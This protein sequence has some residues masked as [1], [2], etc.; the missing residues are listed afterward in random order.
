[1]SDNHD[2]ASEEQEGIEIIPPKYHITYTDIFLLEETGEVLLFHNENYSVSISVC[3]MASIMNPANNVP[4]KLQGQ[5][6]SKRTSRSRMVEFCTSEYPTLVEE[7]FQPGC[8]RCEDNSFII[9]KG[10]L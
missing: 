10:W 3:H 5:T 2:M 6:S 7:R 1:M 9:Q 4:T 8:Q